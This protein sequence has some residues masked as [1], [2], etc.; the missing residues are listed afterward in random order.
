VAQYDPLTGA[1]TAA[2]GSQVQLGTTGPPT[3][4]GSESWQALLLSAAGS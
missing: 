3:G 1:A 4:L 2:D